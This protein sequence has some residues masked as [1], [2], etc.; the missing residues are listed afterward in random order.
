MNRGT[1]L[2]EVQ[3]YVLLRQSTLSADDK[4]RIFLENPD[5]KY[6]PVMKALRLL[7]S[8]FFPSSADWQDQQS[9]QSLWHNAGWREG[10]PEWCWLLCDAISA[11]GRWWCFSRISGG[12]DFSRWPRCRCC[13]SLR[14]RVRRLRASTPEM[15]MALVTYLEARQH[16]QE[17]RRFRGFWPTGQSKSKGK[18]KAMAVIISL[19][20]LPSLGAVCAI[21]SAIGEQSVPTRTATLALRQLL[22]RQLQQPIW[23]N[24]PWRQTCLPMTWRSFLRAIC[25]WAGSVCTGLFHVSS[26]SME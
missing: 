15:H 26:H 5:L 18:G 22:H 8:K 17:K 23:L 11:C 24:P 16:L 1:S 21:R 10:Q 19:P 14:D 13:A 25:C 9:H 4:K 20:R 7:G 3:A 2:E 6:H 12:N